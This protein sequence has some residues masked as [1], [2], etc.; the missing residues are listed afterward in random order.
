MADKPIYYGSTAKMAYGTNRPAYYGRGPVYYGAGLQY[1][2]PQGVADAE[3]DA[4][5]LGS[6]TFGRI[7]R[8]VTQRWL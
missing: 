8:V 6:L 7:L 1:G 3:N 2:A 4:T 5:I